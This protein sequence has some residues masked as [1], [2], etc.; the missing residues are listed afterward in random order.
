MHMEC[1]RKKDMYHSSS[2]APRLS[3]VRQSLK[4]P[5]VDGPGY[6]P[7]ARFRLENRLS[8]KLRSSWARLSHVLVGSD[9]SSVAHRVC[10][11]ATERVR[12]M[13]AGD[14]VYIVCKHQGGLHWAR[15]T[16]YLS[17]MLKHHQR[18]GSESY[19][20]QRFVYLVEHHLGQTDIT[21]TAPFSADALPHAS[22]GWPVMPNALQT[23]RSSRLFSTRTHGLQS[24]LVCFGPCRCKKRGNTTARGCLH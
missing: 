9:R 20:K 13:R 15:L 8:C 19:C 6:V 3:G 14:M 24:R 1:Q 17:R 2:A 12:R 22:R 5:L 23:V 11:T 4:Q 7:A 21:S 16:D 10:H 18:P